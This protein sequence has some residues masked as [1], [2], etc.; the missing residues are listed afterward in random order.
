MITEYLM[1]L[2]IFQVG[3][4]YLWLN[5]LENLRFIRLHAY[6]DSSWKKKAYFIWL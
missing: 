3:I 4:L 1:Q 5:F 2:Y 6:S